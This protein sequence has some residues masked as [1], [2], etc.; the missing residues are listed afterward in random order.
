LRGQRR[1]TILSEA[2]TDARLD[3]PA[4]SAFPG[5]SALGILLPR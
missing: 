2:M 3:Q 5:L 1:T 4:A